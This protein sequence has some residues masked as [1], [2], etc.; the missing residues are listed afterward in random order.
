[1]LSARTNA[2]NETRRLEDTQ[3]V[4]GAVPSQMEIQCECALTYMNAVSGKNLTG[5]FSL[6]KADA[7]VTHDTSGALGDDRDRARFCRTTATWIWGVSDPLP[8]EA[9]GRDRGVAEGGRSRP[10][11]LLHC[12]RQPRQL[13]HGRHKAPPV[14]VMPSRSVQKTLTAHD[15]NDQG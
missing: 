14:A 4:D 5:V 6:M 3:E 13:R 10:R 15:H 7:S 9:W 11:C 2:T 8:A 1:M 12:C